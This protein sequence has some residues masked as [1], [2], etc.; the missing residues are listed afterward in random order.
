MAVQEISSSISSISALTQKSVEG[1]EE[2]A[3]NS[4]SVASMADVLRKAIDFFKIKSD[5]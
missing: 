4:R 2:F 3:D 5:S 1:A